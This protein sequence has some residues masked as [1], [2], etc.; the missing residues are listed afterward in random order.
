MRSYA[1][2]RKNQTKRK[3]RVVREDLEKETQYYNERPQDQTLI[4]NV[5]LL[6]L[7]MWWGFTV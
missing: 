7:L 2:L 5:P 6:L 4:L 3:E 1:A